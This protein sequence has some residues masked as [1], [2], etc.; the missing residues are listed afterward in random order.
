MNENNEQQ[1]LNVDESLNDDD[2]Y[3]YLH[4]HRLISSKPYDD[5]VDYDHKTVMMLVNVNRFD[6][7]LANNFDYD[8]Y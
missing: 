8:D 6:F 1:L 2:Y 5:F 4:Y 7:F 3:Y